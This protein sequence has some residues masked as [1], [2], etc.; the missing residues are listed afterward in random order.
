MMSQERVWAIMIREGHLFG[1]FG[2]SFPGK[3]IYHFLKNLPQILFYK[4]Y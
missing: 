1:N 3:H 2:L 4:E